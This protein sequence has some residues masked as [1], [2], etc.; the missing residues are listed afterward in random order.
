VD[1]QLLNLLLREKP[2]GVTKKYSR[3]LFAKGEKWVAA[4]P[5]PITAKIPIHPFNPAYLAVANAV[6]TN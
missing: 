3:R 6:V 4:I 2:A 1:A 5:H